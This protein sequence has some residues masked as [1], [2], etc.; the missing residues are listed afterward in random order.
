MEN[1][2]VLIAQYFYPTTESTCIFPV[3][4]EQ[5]ALTG[6]VRISEPVEVDFTPRPGAEVEAAKRA[7]LEKKRAAL[8]AQLAKLE[9]ATA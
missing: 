9:E 3:S 1:G 6:A 2:K 8:A 5:N 4:Y 7:V